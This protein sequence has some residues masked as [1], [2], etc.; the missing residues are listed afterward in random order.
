MQRKYLPKFN[1][2]IRDCNA[3]CNCSAKDSLS[4]FPVFF[5]RMMNHKPVTSRP[6]ASRH[7]AEINHSLF[8]GACSRSLWY[9]T[10]RSGTCR[11]KSGGFTFEEVM[12]AVALTC[13][14]AIGGM[15]YQ[16]YSIKDNQIAQAQVMATRIGQLLLEDWKSMAGDEDYDPE[17]L[18]LGF[19][20]TTGKEFGNYRIT[21]GGQTFYLLKQFN[22]V[23]R[24]DLA[25]VTLREINITV[26]WRWDYAK[27]TVGDTDPTISLTTYVRRDQ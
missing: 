26:K 22:D 10:P 15:G 25:G 2:K 7:F 3:L 4:R 17:S 27:G 12:I 9:R 13:V 1:M 16:Y 18:K 14:L 11:R 6:I 23:D 20:K 21:L 24:D 5:N 8:I 19:E